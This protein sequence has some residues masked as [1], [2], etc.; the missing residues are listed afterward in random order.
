MWIERLYKDKLFQILK[1]FPAI[2]ISGARQVGKTTL[3]Q[4]LLPDY[5]YVSLDDSRTASFAQSNPDQFLSQFKNHV[6]ID[7]IQY[8]PS[9]FRSIKVRID[10]NRTSVKY[11]LTGSQNFL[12]IKGVQESLAGRCGIMTLLPLCFQE[13]LSVPD[14]LQKYTVNELILRGGYPEIWKTDMH[15]TSWFQNYVIT[16]LERDIRNILSVHSLRDFDR[17]LRAAAFRTGQILSLTDLAK[18]VGISVS[19]AKE[20]LSVLQ[21]SHQ[22]TLVEPYFKNIGKRIIKSPKLYFN[23]TGLACFLNGITNVDYLM[24]SHLLGALWETYVFNQLKTLSTVFDDQR[25]IWFWRTATGE[26]VD[27]VLDYGGKYRLFEVK[28]SENIN[29]MD[30]KG[31]QA[32]KKYYTPD[33]VIDATIISSSTVQYA[34][35]D[36]QVIFAGSNPFL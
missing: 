9:L 20:W 32:F 23:D 31:I 5:E 15:P 30:L 27:F 8:V 18:D 4:K 16:Y 6:I 3:I 25:T 2:Y 1:D 13:L 21:A 28:Y 12:M 34:I 11:V 10:Q 29:S 7:E 14:L 36:V 26:E 22:V 33:S 19:T 24:N 17:F 35:Q